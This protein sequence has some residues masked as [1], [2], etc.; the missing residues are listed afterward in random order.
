MAKIL[1]ELFGFDKKSQKT[2][3]SCAF[4]DVKVDGS[5]EMFEASSP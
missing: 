3:N 1:T 2:L 4:L 5:G